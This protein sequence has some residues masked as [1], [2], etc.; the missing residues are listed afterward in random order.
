M[1]HKKSN[2]KIHL[3]YRENLTITFFI[4][5]VYKYYVVKFVISL[6]LIYLKWLASKYPH[7]IHNL[8]PI[9]IRYDFS[10][11]PVHI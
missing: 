11:F 10:I 1:Y 5:F 4:M 7:P 8:V 9:R 2:L 6:V 3:L